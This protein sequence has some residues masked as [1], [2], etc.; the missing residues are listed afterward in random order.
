MQSCWWVTRDVGFAGGQPGMWG[1]LVG[2]KGCVVAG[3]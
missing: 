3:G 2:D 1:L